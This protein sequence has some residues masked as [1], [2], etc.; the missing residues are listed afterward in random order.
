MH[1]VILLLGGNLGNVELTLIQARDLIIE[2]IGEIVL[3][4]DLYE[5]EPWGFE[6]AQN[7][8]NQVIEVKS[9]Y[10]PKEILKITQGI[11]KELGRKQKTSTYYEGRLIDIDILFYDDKIID[12]AELRIPH[13][14]LHERKFT[15]LPLNEKWS[16]LEH[17]I[18]K[19]KIAELTKECIDTCWARLL[20]A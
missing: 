14:K 1:H 7:F 9:E 19:K 4:S 13:P 17:P 15:L 10:S 8:L 5:S 16:D 12:L 6:H 2:E 11:E 3:A 18:L 20:K